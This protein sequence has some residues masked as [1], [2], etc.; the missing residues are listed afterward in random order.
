M[1]KDLRA[2]IDLVRS[3]LPDHYVRID[4]RTDPRFGVTAILGAFEERQK[5]PVVH[6][7]D[8]LD[9]EGKP[10]KF[11]VLANLFASRDRLALAMGVPVEKLDDAYRERQKPVKPVV[12]GAGDSPVKHQVWTGEKLNLF[13]IPV[14]TH[15]T[16]D[17]GAYL[18]AGSVWCPDPETGDINCAILR[19]CVKKKDMLLVNFEPTRHMSLYF[20]RYK[21]KGRKAP[22]IICIGHHPLFYCGQTKLLCNEPDIIG[23]IMGEPLL[24]T[25]SETWGKDLCIP[26]EAEIVI[27]GYV[28]TDLEEMEGPIGEF[29]GYYGAVKESPVMEAT[30]LSLRENPVYLDIFVGHADH[31]ILD[32]PVI[33]GRIIEELRSA[34]PSVQDI[35]IPNSGSGRFNCYIRLKGK[36][37]DIEPRI[38]MVRALTSYFLLKNV[39]VVDEDV[40]IYSDEEILWAIT[41]RVQWD[42]DIVILPKM[43]GSVL[44]TCYCNGGVTKMAIDATKPLGTKFPERLDIPRNELDKARSILKSLKLL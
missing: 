36:R 6:F 5:F 35:H 26:A 34:V 32:T 10:S 31:F 17:G 1:G 44:D 8:V 20:E 28:R 33:A 43:Q 22:V 13:S 27:E 9:M 18:T 15:H 14:L 7:T 3:A 41:T 39:V 4:T 42:K 38:A 25:P 24:L 11:T 37:N 21:A 2:Y 30:A 19:V 12:V 16:K 23:G 29:T 40:N